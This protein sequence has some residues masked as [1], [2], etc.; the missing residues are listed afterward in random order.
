MKKK[1]LIIERLELL[2]RLTKE[3]TIELPAKKL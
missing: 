1:E 2:K 3:L